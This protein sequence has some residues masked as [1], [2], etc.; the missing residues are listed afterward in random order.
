MWLTVFSFDVSSIMCS[1]SFGCL[2]KDHRIEFGYF[3]H[4]IIP[5]I[6]FWVSAL[7]QDHMDTGSPAKPK[8]SFPFKDPEPGAH[9]SFPTQG[10][11]ITTWDLQT[12]PL[13]S[14]LLGIPLSLGWAH[15]LWFCPGEGSDIRGNEWVGVTLLSSL[16]FSGPSPVTGVPVFLV[17]PQEEA[18]CS[19]KPLAGVRTPG[20]VSFFVTFLLS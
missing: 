3:I 16:S 19:K 12:W 4:L 11:G 20:F 6:I 14:V 15:Q 18:L 1:K 8:R 10:L 7:C 5:Q 9:V 2:I 17:F 13:G